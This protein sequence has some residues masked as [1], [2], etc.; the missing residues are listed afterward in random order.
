MV[1]ILFKIVLVIFCQLFPFVSIFSMQQQVEKI[2]SGE[3]SRGPKTILCLNE[4]ESQNI[5]SYLGAMV[6]IHSNIGK[7]NVEINFNERNFNLKPCIANCPII[8]DWP[9]ANVEDQ[10]IQLLN[11]L[12]ERLEAVR[13][14]KSKETLQDVLFD[15][16]GFLL[17][18]SLLKRN[19]KLEIGEKF[20]LSQERLL[21][22]LAIKTETIKSVIGKIQK[23][24]EKGK[25]QEQ[26]SLS[27]EDHKG[28]NDTRKTHNKIYGLITYEK[29]R[30]DLNLE[31]GGGFRNESNYNELL[32]SFFNFR[33]FNVFDT[34]VTAVKNDKFET[35]TA[36]LNAKPI[37]EIMKEYKEEDFYSSLDRSSAQLLAV[38]ASL[39][40]FMDAHCGNILGRIQD[41]KIYPIS[42]DH[43]RIL[44]SNP[45]SKN[46]FDCFSY[47][48][49]MDGHLTL[50]VSNFIDSIN[51]E[52]EMAL[53]KKSMEYLENSNSNI[54]QEQKNEK[55]KKFHIGLIVL[56]YIKEKNFSLNK[57]LQLFHP[58]Q[59]KK[60][61]MNVILNNVKKY[62]SE[63]FDQFIR[64]ILDHNF[65]S[66]EQKKNR[67]ERNKGYHIY[68]EE[69]K[70][71]V[72]KYYLAP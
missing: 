5:Y 47:W 19:K 50:E 16:K 28:I 36:H 69:L 3:I 27:K 6:E 63:R 11:K 39:F 2:N 31:F 68:L 46:R 64:N 59:N 8:N 53:M 32:V 61:F 51:I 48:P 14:N 22:L 21:S 23:K 71:V 35:Q 38:Q 60:S 62:P 25:S 20:L 34:S 42:I 18:T 7:D 55:L 33:H 1:N 66:D 54:T 15:I 70:S 72:K 41:G 49:I 45:E 4:E 30:N 65:N 58:V 26:I 24:I 67:K 17:L 56:K 52:N 43:G 40:S 44:S 13:E 9:V 12:I 37:H 10:M 29:D 57:L